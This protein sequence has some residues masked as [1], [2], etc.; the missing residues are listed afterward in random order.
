MTTP[1][2]RSSPRFPENDGRVRLSL[3]ERESTLAYVTGDLRAIGECEGHRPRWRELDRA[4]VGFDEKRVRSAA[5]DEESDVRLASCWAGDCS[6]DVGQAY[7]ADLNQVHDRR[8]Q[9]S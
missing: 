5:I 9:Q 2:S 8:A 1:R 7:C 3:R 4:P 6:V